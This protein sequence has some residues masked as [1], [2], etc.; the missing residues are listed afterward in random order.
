MQTTGKRQHFANILAQLSKNVDHLY[1]FRKY[2]KETYFMILM[3]GRN[4]K[5]NYTVTLFLKT[6]FLNIKKHICKYG[7]WALFIMPIAHKYTIIPYMR[8]VFRDNESIV[9][10]FYVVYLVISY[11]ILWTPIVPLNI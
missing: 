7:Q 3:I 2:F 1:I 11:H 8:F 6:S 10:A 9:M 5:I 4:H